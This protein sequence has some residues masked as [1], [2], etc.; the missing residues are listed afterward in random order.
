[1]ECLWYNKEKTFY[2]QVWGGGG[3]QSYKLKIS[4]LYQLFIFGKYYILVLNLRFYDVERTFPTTR[5][6]LRMR[7]LMFTELSYL[8]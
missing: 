6:K 3:V 8:L 2:L 7:G 4:I 5:R 1:M